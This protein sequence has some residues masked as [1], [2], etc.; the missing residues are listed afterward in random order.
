MAQPSMEQR[1][2]HRP[3]SPR[4]NARKRHHHNQ[5]QPRRRG[6]NNEPEVPPIAKDPAE[7]AIAKA[8]KEASKFKTE[9]VK[10]TSAVT[11]LMRQIENDNAWKWANNEDNKGELQQKSH[12]LS[13]SLTT[14]QYKYLTEDFAT[15]KRK[16]QGNSTN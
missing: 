14:M 16:Q 4:P 10:V 13:T 2:R 8:N 6:G 7:A 11:L 5:R 1:R 9:F 12:D 15:L 3:H